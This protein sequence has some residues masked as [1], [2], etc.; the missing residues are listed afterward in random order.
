MCPIPA[1]GWSL[2]SHPSGVWRAFVVATQAPSQWVTLGS[3]VAVAV[4]V[5]LITSRA[6]LSGARTQAA[7][8]ARS[9]ALVEIE[10]QVKLYKD[11]LDSQDRELLEERTRYDRLASD[12][13]EKNAR[14]GNLEK[15][16]VELSSMVDDLRAQLTEATGGS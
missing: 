14:L 3:G 9:A 7:G 5:A 8:D 12:M 16:V 1:Y 13:R 11:R 10:F 15:T 4:V 2:M 6:A